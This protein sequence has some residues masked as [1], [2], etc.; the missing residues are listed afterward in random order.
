MKY[1]V[2]LSIIVLISLCLTPGFAFDGNRKPSPEELREL[3]TPK[4]LTPEE[5]EA[6]NQELETEC[7]L[8]S[9]DFKEHPPLSENDIIQNKLKNDGP[10]P[11]VTTP[12]HHTF[13]ADCIH[14]WQ[15]T[16]II[17]NNPAAK[18][19]YHNDCPLC[20]QPLNVLTLK[21]RAFATFIIAGG[22][23]LALKYYILPLVKKNEEKKDNNKP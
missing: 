3:T 10:P 19:E 16:K 8:C 22:T 23:A 20:G 15:N 9:Q 21:Q 5:R 12:C 11:L 6:L 2:L 14:K 1:T 18:P 13:H 17:N 4:Q 7:S